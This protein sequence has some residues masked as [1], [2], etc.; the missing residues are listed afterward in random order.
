[1]TY[2][3]ETEGLLPHLFTVTDMVTDNKTTFDMDTVWARFISV[4]SDTT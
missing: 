2:R 3:P 4:N 1:M